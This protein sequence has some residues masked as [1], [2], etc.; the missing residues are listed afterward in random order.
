MIGE[1]SSGHL[2]GDPAY[3][4][5]GV[6]NCSV[7]A[8]GDS[9]RDG[10]LRGLKPTRTCKNGAHGRGPPLRAA[11]CGWRLAGV[12]VARDLAEALPLSVLELNVKHET[13]WDRGRSSRRR[14]LRAPWCRPASLPHETLELVDRNELWP[15]GHFHGLEQRQHSPVEGRSAH[16]ERLSGLRPCVG[17]SLD[18]RRPTYGDRRGARRRMRV[19]LRFLALAP[20]PPTGHAYERTQTVA[21]NASTM[22]LRL[23]CYPGW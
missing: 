21:R 6:V 22:H 11:V 18:V 17:E 5:R 14:R 3:V 23:A 16:P 8:R 12:E 19:T 9:S 20:L 4:T 13:V 15:P 7:S 10:P 2:V 1:A